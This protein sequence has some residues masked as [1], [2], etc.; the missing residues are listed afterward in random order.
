VSDQKEQ[1]I[2]CSDCGKR[3]PESQVVYIDRHIGDFYEIE[4]ASPYPIFLKCTN[5]ESAAGRV[6]RAIVL[7]LA[8]FMGV[9][10]YSKL[11]LSLE[12]AI[13]GDDYASRRRAR[14]FR[15]ANA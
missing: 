11:R 4:Y 13:R 10:L 6:Y 14:M 8:L 5:S 2:K 9:W 1:T 15:T 7:V 12:N 3:V